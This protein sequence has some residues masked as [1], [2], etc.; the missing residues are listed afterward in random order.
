MKQ[1]RHGTADVSGHVDQLLHALS[2]VIGTAAFCDRP[3]Q[4]RVFD[5]QRDLEQWERLVL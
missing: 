3:E 4:R 1:E 2:R 5:H